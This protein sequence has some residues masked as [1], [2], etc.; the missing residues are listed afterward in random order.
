MVPSALPVPAENALTRIWVAWRATAIPMILVPS[1]VMIALPAT[2]PLGQSANA[3][4][5]LLDHKLLP[6]AVVS[7]KW[8]LIVF[9]AHSST[10][11]VLP[12][13]V[14][15]KGLAPSS[16]AEM[17]PP[18]RAPRAPRHARAD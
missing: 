3:T 4:A 8:T 1:G 11:R 2:E 15:D 13:A 18:T 17:Y 12:S 5:I 6:A 14:H 7:S 10:A 16:S 9:P